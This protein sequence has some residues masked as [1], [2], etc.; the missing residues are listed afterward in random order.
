MLAGDE[1]DFLSFSLLVGEREHHFPV[2]PISLISSVGI[3]NVG[4]CS[5]FFSL[6]RANMMPT[7]DQRE[8]L[9][10]E[11]DSFFFRKMRKESIHAGASFPALEKEINLRLVP[12][13]ISFSIR[14]EKNACLCRHGF[15]SIIL[16]KKIKEKVNSLTDDP[17]KRKGKT[18]RQRIL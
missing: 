13:H 10:Q 11:N 3:I 12:Q 17:N 2:E 5:F 1:I 14:A 7:G 9:V 16:F 15:L 18:D 4:S 6:F 8:K